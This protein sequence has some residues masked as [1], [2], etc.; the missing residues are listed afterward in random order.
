MTRAHHTGCP[1]I[2]CVAVV[3]N[4]NGRPLLERHLPSILSALPHEKLIVVDN[5]STDDSV[6]LLKNTF[7]DVEVIARAENG[8]FSVAVNEGI[9]RAG[10][11]DLLIVLNNDVEVAPGFLDSIL[12]LFEDEDVFAVSPRILLPARH[13][14]DEGPTTGFWHHGMFYT[15]QRQQVQEVTPIL[16]ATG[17]AAVYRRSMLDELG[18]FDEVY[19]PFYWEDAD[20]GYRAWKRGWKTLYQPASEVIHQHAASIS[21]MDPVFTGRIKARNGLFFIWR[22]IEDKR[23]LAAHRRWLPLVAVRRRLAGDK[24]FVSGL[25]EATRRRAEMAEARTRD[26]VFRRLSDCEI[27]D[28]LGIRHR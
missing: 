6:E 20:L 25:I 2:R 1:G 19:S 4:W 23:M 5:G 27:F 16:Y 28:T 22:N 3:P 21:K 13:G 11:C 8:G 26:S 17:C 12:P 18:G 9:R 10:S 7:A 14:L 15:G 24:A